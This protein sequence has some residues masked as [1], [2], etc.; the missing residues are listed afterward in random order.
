MKNKKKSQLRVF[1]YSKISFKSKVEIVSAKKNW[2]TFLPADLLYK[3]C[4]KKLFSRR[5]VIPY[6]NFNVHKEMKCIANTI[7][8]GKINFIL[9]SHF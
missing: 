1:I 5:N 8:N 9:S 7:S 3:K 6:Q 2:G 4:Q